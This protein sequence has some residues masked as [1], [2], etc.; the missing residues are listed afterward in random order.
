[1]GD[2]ESSAPRRALRFGTVVEQPFLLGEQQSGDGL[3]V[4]LV[5]IGRG[6]KEAGELLGDRLHLD[7]RSGQVAEGAARRFGKQPRRPLLSDRNAHSFGV[8]N[9]ASTCPRASS[10]PVSD[11][12]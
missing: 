5:E 6:E 3:A 8:R 11:S 1:M 4:L 7:R 9:S 10:S 2:G 12:L